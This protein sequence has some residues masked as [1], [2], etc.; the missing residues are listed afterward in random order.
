[1]TGRSEWDVF[2]A[3]SEVG[4]NE[5]KELPF[6]ACATGIVADLGILGIRFS[7]GGSLP[8]LLLALRREVAVRLCGPDAGR[9][10]LHWLGCSW[11]YLARCLSQDRAHK[12][13]KWQK[14]LGTVQQ[15]KDKKGG[16]SK[17]RLPKAGKTA[18]G[19]LHMARCEHAASPLPRRVQ[20]R[21]GKSYLCSAGASTP[22]MCGEDICK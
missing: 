9:D 17:K 1:M 14:V 5:K 18:S 11:R 21:S 10:G 3:K 20:L 7:T 22:A 13:E 6:P 2:L 19:T 16:R 4:K 15:G 12:D 8:R